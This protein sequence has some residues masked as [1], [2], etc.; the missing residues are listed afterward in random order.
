MRV[1]GGGWRFT[2]KLSWFFGRGHDFVSRL[3]PVLHCDLAFIGLELVHCML[4]RHISDAV[5]SGSPLLW[6]LLAYGFFD[7]LD[8]K[9]SEQATRALSKWLKGKPYENFEVRLVILGAF[10][11]LYSSPLFRLKAFFRSAVVSLL[12][13]LAFLIWST[14]ANL[15]LAEYTE[16]NRL[17]FST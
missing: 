6:A 4:L 15:L 12:V 7:W 10:D 11:N 2:S 1:C 3:G 14:W 8:R 5:G 9:A 13:F 16:A 17:F